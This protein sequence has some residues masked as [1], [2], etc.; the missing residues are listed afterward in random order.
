MKLPKQEFKLSSYQE[1]IEL[2]D[3]AGIGQKI[4]LDFVSVPLVLVMTYT[5]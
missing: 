5:V 3:F 4:Q 2:S 1:G